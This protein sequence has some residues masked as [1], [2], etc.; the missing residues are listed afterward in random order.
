MSG[1]IFWETLLNLR[2]RM[3]RLSYWRKLRHIKLKC[4]IVDNGPGMKE[5]TLSH[6][7]DI[8]YQR[9]DGS[10]AA[11][12]MALSLS[13]S[14]LKFFRSAPLK[15]STHF[16]IQKDFRLFEIPVSLIVCPQACGR[17]LV[18]DFK[19]EWAV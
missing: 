17:N 8:Y 19:Y 5:E 13:L 14:L 4:K 3:E 15:A 1:S 10:M 2:R 7:F 16:M 6:I 12:K 18:P 9:Q 11:M